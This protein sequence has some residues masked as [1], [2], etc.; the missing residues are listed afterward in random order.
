MT[1]LHFKHPI[2]VVTLGWPPMKGG[3]AVV[4]TN[5]LSAIT[6][7]SA[8]VATI[9]LKGAVKPPTHGFRLHQVMW[10]RKISGRLEGIIRRV[11]VPFVARR[12]AKLAK[13]YDCR[14]ILGVYPDLFML[15]SAYEASRLTGLPFIP[16]LHDT[17]AEALSVRKEAAYALRLQKKLFATSANIFV[18]SGGMR[19]LYLQKYNLETTALCHTFPEEIPS[20]PAT[21]QVEPNGFHSGSV[22]NINE[23]AL[24]RVK[25]ALHRCNMSLYLTTVQNKEFIESRGFKGVKM[26]FMETRADLL[27]TLARQSFLILALDWVDETEG[28]ADELGT[29]FPTKTIEYLASGRPI[30]LHCP[31]NYFLTRFCQ[32]HDCAEIVNERSEDALVAAMERLRTDKERALQL[33]RNAL[34]TA[35]M[36]SLPQIAQTFYD[37]VA[38]HLED[39]A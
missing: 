26:G 12:L 23:N 5:L 10:A 8:V 9:D 13:K 17:L 14:A 29:I 38:P 7:E 33:S 4:M 32:E 11:Q 36:F 1:Q 37:G 20:E 22:Y 30:L 6:K 19:D 15:S 2:L 21:G 18:M 39:K 28:H 35:A 34:R 27:A 16:Y 24:L 3:A 25:H 31:E